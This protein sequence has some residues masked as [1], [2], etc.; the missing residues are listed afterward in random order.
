M[1]RNEIVDLKLLLLSALLIGEFNFFL[2]FKS[3]NLDLESNKLCR[4][5]R[6]IRQLEITVQAP[7]IVDRACN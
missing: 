4:Y 2:E 5:Q 1:E 3:V 6:T 7:K